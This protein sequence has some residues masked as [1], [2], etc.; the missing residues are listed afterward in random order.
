MFASALAA[1]IALAGGE[2]RADGKA[3]AQA[4]AERDGWSDPA[5]PARIHGN[6]YFVGTCGITVL[7][8]TGSDGHVLI[9]GATAEAAPAI[10][11][12]IKALGFRP[13]DV[14]LLVA[15]HEH[16]DHVGGFAALREATG[17]TVA[18]RAPARAV[19][20][21]GEIDRAD[22]QA[23]SL[24]PMAPVRVGRIVRDGEKV[25]VGDTS[26]TAH[27]TAGHTD[28][29]T[30]WTWR[31]CEAGAC[32]AIAYVDSL[33]AVSADSYRFSDH[34]ERVAP[35]RATF[36][37]LAALD[38]DVLVTPHP[39]ASDLFARL[40]GDKPLVDK[41]ACGRLVEGARARLDTRLAEERTR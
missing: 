21:T 3:L 22:P 13:Q 19:L 4:C 15:S 2:P 7:L 14:K 1:L 31:S 24:E 25:A 20:E 37:R 28:G 12:N 38:C 10:L 36:D 39:V 29:G 33:S 26:L 40:A 34:P 30:S 35:F 17:A 9:D 18:V 32:V 8:V 41:A 16:L 23:G 11:A 27:A 6:T 5:P